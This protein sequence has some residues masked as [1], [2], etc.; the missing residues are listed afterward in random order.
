MEQLGYNL[1]FCWFVGLSL[2]VAVWDVTVFN[3]LPG[4]G[5][6]GSPSSSVL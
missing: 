1:L 2:D 5:E 4:P 3:P 6:P